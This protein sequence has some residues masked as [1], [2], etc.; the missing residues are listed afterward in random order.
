MKSLKWLLGIALVVVAASVLLRTFVWT[1]KDPPDQDDEDQ[2][3][4]VQA[5]SRVSV[6][7]GQTVVTLDE[8]TQKRI[9]IAVET[10]RAEETREQATAVATILPVQELIALRSAFVA[11]KSQVEKAQVSVSV[12]RKEYERLKSLYQENQNA[13]LKSV[14]AADAALRTDKASLKAAQQELEVQKAASVQNWG[15]VV[16]GWVAAGAG[17]LDRVLSHQELLVQV[18]LAPGIAS[19]APRAIELST[20]GGGQI[21]AG[22]ISPLPRVDPRIQRATLLYSMASH[23]GL[24]PGLNLVASLPIGQKLKGVRVPRSAIVWWQGQPWAYEQTAS[25]QF[26]REQV[27][28]ATPLEAGYFE[29]AGFVPG[30]MIV[31]QGAQALLSEEF[32]SKIQPED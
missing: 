21:H 22:Y 8:A 32:R 14:Q 30:S 12:S 10:L 13:S 7:H 28:T 27:L 23:P 9:G 11:A 2:E 25:R 19:A 16:A 24:A 18:T 15:S 4:S 3:E 20:P 17:R 31:I 26:T 1:H 6:I 29:T 5:P